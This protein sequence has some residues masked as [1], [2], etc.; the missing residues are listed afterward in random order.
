MKT[1]IVLLLPVFAICAAGQA[2]KKPAPQPPAKVSA[3]TQPAPLVQIPAGAVETE[4]GVYRFADSA[5][6]KWVYRKTP[7][8]ISRRE[9]TPEDAPKPTALDE[10]IKAFDAGDAVRFERTSPF[11]VTKWVKKK[12]DL[13]DQERSVWERD[14]AR[15]EKSK[16]DDK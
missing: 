5:G 3:Q 14:K 11:G 6:K 4:P 7:F 16:Q 13:N 12:S 15:G 10:Y 1:L 8:G 2:A 9:D